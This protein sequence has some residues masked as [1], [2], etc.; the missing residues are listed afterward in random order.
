MRG[1]TPFD[2][3]ISLVAE[4]MDAFQ[5]CYTGREVLRCKVSAVEGDRAVSMSPS[6]ADQK[7]SI[8][9]LLVLLIRFSVC[10]SLR[11]SSLSSSSAHCARDGLLSECAKFCLSNK[12]SSPSSS[13]LEKEKNIPQTM[14]LEAHFLHHLELSTVFALS[15]APNKSESRKSVLKSVSTALIQVTDA[16][17]R[18]SDGSLSFKNIDPN[19][20]L[21]IVKAWST[22]M[23]TLGSHSKDSDEESSFFS[24]SLKSSLV[25]VIQLSLYHT[26]YYLTGRNA[27][28]ECYGPCNK[29]HSNR[30]KEDVLRSR[31]DDVIAHSAESDLGL[32]AVSDSSGEGGS[33]AVCLADDGHNNSSDRSN[34][35]K[36]MNKESAVRSH[37]KSEVINSADSV[38]LRS[39]VVS[40]YVQLINQCK[41]EKIGRDILEGH[42]T[43]I[44]LLSESDTLSGVIITIMKSIVASCEAKHAA[45]DLFDAA[46]HAVGGQY[47][48]E[49]VNFR[50]STSTSS[51]D[52]NRNIPTFHDV[53][54]LIDALFSRNI[55]IEE[56]IKIA[57]SAECFNEIRDVLRKMEAIQS[58]IENSEYDIS[59]GK[60]SLEDSE[61]SPILYFLYKVATSGIADAADRVL[62]VLIESWEPVQTL[63]HTIRET[64]PGAIVNRSATIPSYT[65]E[66]DS[67]VKTPHHHACCAMFLAYSCVEGHMGGVEFLCAGRL[68]M[69]ILYGCL[70]DDS[71][72]ADA[73]SYV[74]SLKSV[75]E[76]NCNICEGLEVEEDLS[77]YFTHPLPEQSKIAKDTESESEAVEDVAAAHG[78]ACDTNLDMVI[79]RAKVNTEHSHTDDSEEGWD[80][81]SLFLSVV[82]SRLASP[83]PI[84]LPPH[85]VP[86]NNSELEDLISHIISLRTQHCT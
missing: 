38:A 29:T 3:M 2:R 54:P 70:H 8:R 59:G 71:I 51:R 53:Y 17:L 66:S 48:Q 49:D 69:Q 33:T 25:C 74:T 44:G 6:G 26:G 15:Y 79:D 28:A 61:I 5:E 57:F 46:S 58:L 67:R 1:D 60:S 9:A 73:R 24:Q 84:V 34:T 21:H 14:R 86:S 12:E 32:V 37:S 27:G 43:V 31:T 62:S 64:F 83:V 22:L 52:G 85:L 13:S 18:P 23:G 41:S 7:E 30:L 50:K 10:S 47:I 20:F 76:L 40:L 42:S 36:N 81:I 19:L 16:L 82:R 68:M 4:N 45:H 63:F 65:I 56:V 11:S 77:V 55:I 80:Q 75:T 78:I 35:R 72:S 39:H